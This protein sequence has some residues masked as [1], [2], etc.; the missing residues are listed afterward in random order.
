VEHL[1]T[2]EEAGLVERRGPDSGNEQTTWA[3]IGQGV[4]F[5]IPED[6]EGQRPR[7]N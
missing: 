5:E 2:L 1:E 3:A 7:G 6:A 4:F